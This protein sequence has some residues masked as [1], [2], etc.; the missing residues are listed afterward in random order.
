MLYTETRNFNSGD[1]IFADEE[2]F[3]DGEFGTM[4]LEQD[5]QYCNVCPQ[6]GEYYCTYE[7]SDC[8]NCCEEM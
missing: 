2:V 8:P 6:C 5:C 3:C 7:E 1:F 4:C